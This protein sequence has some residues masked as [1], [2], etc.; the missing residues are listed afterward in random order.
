MTREVDV[1]LNLEADKAVATAGEFA[2]AMKAADTETNALGR[3]ADETAK[4]MDG[5]AVSAAVAKREVADVGSSA[6]KSS[7][8]L[9]GLDDRIKTAKEN[10]GK[11][12]LEFGKTGDLATKKDLDSAKKALSQLERTRRDILAFAASN[13]AGR[14]A[15]LA[16]AG[17]EEA[18]T[19]GVKD[20]V[21]QLSKLGEYAGPV[22][23]GGLVALS[24]AIGAVL[25][26]AVV[27]AAGLGGIAGGILSA[28]HDPNVQSAAAAFGA[29]IS[30]D[31]FAGG[32][33][34]VQPIEDGLDILSSDFEDLHLDQAFARAAPSVTV[35]AHGIGDF[36]KNLM[37]G[38]NHVLGE[39]GPIISAVAD[40][41]SETGGALSDLLDDLVESPGT[42]QGL[43]DAFHLLGGAIEFLGSTLH[44]L[45]SLYSLLRPIVTTLTAPGVWLFKKE[46]TGVSTGLDALN[47]TIGA[48]LSGNQHIVRGGADPANNPAVKAA[49]DEHQRLAKEMD[50]AAVAADR[51]RSAMAA[52]GQAMDDANKSAHDLWETDLDVA[53]GFLDINEAIKN[54]QKGFDDS[55]QQGVTNQRMVDDEIH[56][57]EAKRDAILASSDASTAEK[58]AAIADYD[59][60]LD[61]LGKL[62]AQLGATKTQLQEING[63]K[64]T[65]YLT[66]VAKVSGQTAAL[67]GDDAAQDLL[68]QHGGYKGHAAGGY[69][70]GTAPFWA[71]E[72]GKELIYPGGP[73]YIATHAQSMA[74]LRQ[75]NGSTG[76]GSGGMQRFAIDLMLNGK[77]LQTIQIDYAQGR[78]VP[79]QKIAAAFP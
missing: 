51:E 64:A 77:Q 39:S 48:P 53:Q 38:F 12:A 18:A 56:R 8:E 3:Q 20:A 70:P 49:A 7:A 13:V 59:A 11:L 76:S 67:H 66:I 78:N 10:V 36:A 52:L 15:T 50:N 23:I 74:M 28:I 30:Q 54:G 69:D 41:L 19:S 34:F 25:S 5:L 16:S 21:Q 4:D 44:I 58:N 33:T 31:F 2:A 61:K 47:D 1:K 37:P 73:S 71:G 27:G 29:K 32:A 60:Q 72:H 55:T 46:W 42:I 45:G 26:G 79:K 6:T 57:L 24:P 35:L 22:L 65:A 62:A 43:V 9:K 17:I 14:A 40:G 68:F 75:W 63:Y